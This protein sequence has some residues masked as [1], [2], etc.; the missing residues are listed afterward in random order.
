MDVGVQLT[1]A[2]GV[3]VAPLLN[4]TEPCAVPKFAPTMF[5]G[6]VPAAPV[7]G[8]RLVRLG[9]IGGAITASKLLPCTAWK[10]GSSVIEVPARK[11]T[12]GPRP[13]T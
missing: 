3:A 10:P 1:I 9:G 13:I 8:V 6:F 5:T 12:D 7:D 4:V 2:A 11:T